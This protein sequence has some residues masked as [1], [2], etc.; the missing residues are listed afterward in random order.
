[1]QLSAPQDAKK[2]AQ[3]AGRLR[4]R[5]AEVQVHAQR[6]PA[7]QALHPLPQ[8]GH[9]LLASSLSS[10]NTILPPP[11][12]C[13]AAVTAPHLPPWPMLQRAA[14]SSSSIRS[15]HMR[16]QP[17][18]Q[19]ALPCV[20]SCACARRPLPPPP[21]AVVVCHSAANPGGGA[22][23]TSAPSTPPETFCGSPLRQHLGLMLRRSRGGTDGADPASAS[24][25]R[26]GRGGGR[27]GCGCRGLCC[28]TGL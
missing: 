6:R 15:S 27:G 13:T 2:P 14:V 22:A 18:G 26:P 10:H 21:L 19:P 17:A 25:P 7:R 4:S 12:R 23:T 28:L 16:L 20:P 3:Q 11:S 1:M 9:A 24:V 5:A 8:Y